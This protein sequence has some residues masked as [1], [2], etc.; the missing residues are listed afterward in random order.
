[1]SDIF[2]SYSK[3]DKDYANQLAGKLR[4]LGFDIWIDN[5]IESG[6]DW[7][8]TIVRAIRSAKAFIVIMSGNSDASE[9]VQREVTLADKQGIPAFPILLSGDFDASENWA[10][11]V[12][13]QYIDVRGGNLPPNE[14]YQRLKQYLSVNTETDVPIPFI[15]NESQMKLHEAI[16]LIIN[17]NG[18]A[19]THAQKIRDEINQRGLYVKKDGTKVE[20]NQIHARTKNYTAMFDKDGSMIRLKNPTN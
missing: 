19:W 9:W 5:R 7:W 16:A 18:N 2:I 6:E 1:M 12:R 11:Y 15:R 4:L 13:T 20:L 3:K 10:I 17:E 14:F 8:R